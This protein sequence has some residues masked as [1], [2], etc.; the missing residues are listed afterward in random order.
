MLFIGTSQRISMIGFGGGSISKSCHRY[1]PHADMAVIDVKARV[2]ALRNQFQFPLIT[3]G[4][5]W[6]AATGGLRIRMH[7]FSPSIDFG[8]V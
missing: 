7:R 6:S 8:W 1:L 5:G 3:I 2:I 4:S